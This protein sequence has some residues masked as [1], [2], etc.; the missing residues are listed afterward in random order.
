M[1][2]IIKSADELYKFRRCLEIFKASGL[3]GDTLMVAIHRMMPRD[4]NGNFLIEYKIK[5]QGARP[6]IFLP[7]NYRI[8]FAVDKCNEWLT[9]NTADIGKEYNVSDFSLY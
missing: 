7:N 6:A 2:N 9:T 5:E 1:S 8:D 3:N 4:K